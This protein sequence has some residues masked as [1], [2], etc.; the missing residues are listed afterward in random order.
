MDF[1]PEM[2]KDVVLS[3]YVEG[4]CSPGGMPSDWKGVVI[5]A[6]QRIIPGP[7]EEPVVPV[8]GFYRVSV[9][10][11]M[12]GEPM[13]VHVRP[14]GAEIEF[15]GLV[16]DEGP[17]EP[18]VP[19]P[20]DDP[21]PSREALEGVYSGGHFNIDAQLYLPNRLIPGAYEVTVTY[22][23]ASSNAVLFEIAPP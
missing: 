12:D 4:A 11:A 7:G 15:S 6:P 13:I 21:E 18:E 3:T 2:Y 9:L 5:T 14:V 1:M 16:A 19:P 22:A 17:D 8:C 23:G 20:G 10:A